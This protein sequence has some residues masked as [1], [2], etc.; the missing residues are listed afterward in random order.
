MRNLALKIS[1]L[2]SPAIQAAVPEAAEE[3]E[4]D[5]PTPTFGQIAKLM[6]RAGVPYIA[7]GFV[8]S[9]SRSL[10]WQRHVQDR[11]GT[12]AQLFSRQDNF[13]MICAG[14]MIDAKFGIMFGLSGLACAGLG[15]TVSGS[16][17]HCWLT[18]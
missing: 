13:I 11:K 10:P 15:N 14:D 4:G 1:S 17:F 12:R 3:E 7:F 8:V 5:V 6:I 9:A 16:S 2:G 18:T